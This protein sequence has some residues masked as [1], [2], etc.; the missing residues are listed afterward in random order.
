MA[1][2]LPLKI[3]ALGA[4]LLAAPAWALPNNNPIPGHPKYTVAQ[5]ISFYNACTANCAASYDAGVANLA[6]WRSCFSGCR[7]AMDSCMAAAKAPIGGVTLHNPTFGEH[8]QSYSP[9]PDDSR[10]RPK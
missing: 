10:Y 8:P 4:L 6:T 2:Q 1:K 3:V 7:P 9:K 5:C